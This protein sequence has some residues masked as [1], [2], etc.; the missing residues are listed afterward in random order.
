MDIRSL[1]LKS[2]DDIVAVNKPAGL[3]T[4]MDGYDASLPYLAGLLQEL[5]GRVWVV[6]R[7]DKETSGVV[8]FARNAPTHRA[9]NIQFQLREIKKEYRALVVGIPSW[10]TNRISLPLKVNGDRS[11]R[12]VIDYQ[13]G[14]PAETEV[15]VLQNFQG[16]SYLSAFPH[17]GYTHQIR[18]HLAATGF[19]LLQ[20]PLYKSR[21]PE[22]R[23]QIEA[24]KLLPSLPI[25][26]CALHAVEITFHHPLTGENMSIQAPEP[27]DFIR[28][29]QALSRC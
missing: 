6:H 29:I 12:T 11:H 1:I 22:T 28:T 9:L 10:E 8:L 27:E 5:F 17:T 21:L 14:K 18:A 13:A 23:F 19:P 16:Y 20:D 25:H 26:R 2:D 15:K 24:Q 4:I 3:C 7:L